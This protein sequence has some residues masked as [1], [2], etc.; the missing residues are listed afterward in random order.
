[1]IITGAKHRLMRVAEFTSCFVGR[2]LLLLPL[3]WHVGSG[4]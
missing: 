3:A 1:M 2:I 4:V